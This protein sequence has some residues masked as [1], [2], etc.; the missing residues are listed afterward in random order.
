MS[1][2]QEVPDA[3]PG[4]QSGP[5]HYPNSIYC[6]CYAC[7]QADVADQKARELKAK[8]S[9]DWIAKAAKE[10]AEEIYPL[11]SIGNL[12]Q[13]AAAIITAA[14]ERNAKL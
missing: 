5:K 8:P 10:A 3:E 4:N 1:T 7:W 14:I 11:D 12:K 9:P 6:Q 2:K 13:N